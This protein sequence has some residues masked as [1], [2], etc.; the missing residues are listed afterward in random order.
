MRR[1]SN[2][3]ILLGIVLFGTG[4]GYPFAA[5]EGLPFYA[6]DRTIGGNE[7]LWPLAQLAERRAVNSDV[8]GSRPAWPALRSR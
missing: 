7:P 5:R 8:A 4:A 1:T 3:T 2:H 6:D